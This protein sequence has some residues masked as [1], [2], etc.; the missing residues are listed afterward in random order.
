MTIEFLPGLPIM[1]MDHDHLVV[2]SCSMISEK[3]VVL[4]GNVASRLAAY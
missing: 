2:G 4:W 3:Y 1:D